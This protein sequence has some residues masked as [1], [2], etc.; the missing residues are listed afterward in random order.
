MIADGEPE[1]VLTPER[2]SDTYGIRIEVS[3]DPSTGRLRTRAIGRHH[4]R[5]TPDG[6]TP[7]AGHTPRND[8]HN[9]RDAHSERLGATS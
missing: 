7:R 4:T 5:R 2:L 3:T 6:D 1:D 9:A 8:K